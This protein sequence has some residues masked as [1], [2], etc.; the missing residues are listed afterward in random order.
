MLYGVFM[1]IRLIDVMFWIL[2]I[3]AFGWLWIFDFKFSVISL[4]PIV[5]LLL[6]KITVLY[7]LGTIKTPKDIINFFK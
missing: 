6:L 7:I 4:T 5:L 1:L 2:V 3:V